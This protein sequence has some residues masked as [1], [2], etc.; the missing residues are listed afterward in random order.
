MTFPAA[1]QYRVFRE[2]LGPELEAEGFS[3]KGSRKAT[4]HRK[5]NEEWYHIIMPELSRSMMRVRVFPTGPATDPCFDLDFPDRLGFPSVDCELNWR[6]GVGE[7]SGGF[8]NLT[9][10]NFRRSLEFMR[11]IFRDK[12]FAVMRTWISVE[13]SLPFITGLLHRA[14]AVASLGRVSEAEPGLREWRERFAHLD[15]SDPCT[16]LIRARIAEILGS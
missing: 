2:V 4:Y 5:V 9:E 14:F 8:R 13:P 1:K 7:S 15:D 3:R 12:A 6:T 16:K 10:P 11:E